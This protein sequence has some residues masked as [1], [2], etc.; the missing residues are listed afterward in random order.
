MFTG[1]SAS[2]W[3][4]VTFAAPV[5]VTAGTTYVASYYAPVGHYSQEE[6]YLYNHPAPRIPSVSAAVAP[7]SAATLRPIRSFA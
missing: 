2:G 5:A 6:A 4:T 1:E 7:F 3:Q